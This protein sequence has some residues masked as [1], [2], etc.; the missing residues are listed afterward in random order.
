MAKRFTDSQIQSLKPTNK[1]A[2]LFEDG[3]RGFGIRIEP[4]GRKSFFLE[5]RF[6]VGKE[7]RNRVLTIGKYPRVSLT[8]ARSIASQSLAHLEQDVDP[9]TQKQTL[10]IANQNAL[11]VAD[12]VTEYIEKWAKVMK[13]ER[14]WKE[15]ERLLKKDIIPVIGRKKA[16]D[17]R[18]RDIV[19]LLDEIVDRGAAITAN[20]VLAVTRKMFNF[21]VGRDIIDASPCV[22]IPAPSKENR[23]ER[24]LSE[25]EIIVFWDK[26][27]DGRMSQEIRLALKFLLV[28]AQRKSEVTDSEWKEFDL[29]KKWWTIPPERAK[30]KQ[31][32]RVPLTPIAIQILKEL[33]QITGEYQFTFASPVGAT[34]RNPDRLPGTVPII[35]SAVDNALRDNLTDD[36]KTKRTNIFNLDHFTPH[37]LRRTAA[38]MMTRSGIQRLTVKK[39]LNHSDREITAVYDRY[40]YDKEKQIAMLAWDRELKKIITN[41]SKAKSKQ[42]LTK[43]K[44]KTPK[45][46]ITNQKKEENNE[47]ITYEQFIKNN[48]LR[49]FTKK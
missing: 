41:Q 1:R 47:V 4:S 19:L 10:I 25:D 31:S 30:N 35:A 7:R 34:K 22:Q 29:E 42:I 36:P 21:A 6:G 23:R 44:K 33:R 38:S 32:H 5:Y 14:S 15:D 43:Q 45:K 9:A 2:I 46:I 26:L 48:K 40:E 8:K 49:D 11:S 13:K 39:I 20:R 28:T 24:N 3:G 18:R 27:R 37:D 12:L 17:I 16:K